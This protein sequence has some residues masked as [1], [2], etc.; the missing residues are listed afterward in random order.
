MEAKKKI[1][2]VKSFGGGGGGL[3]K[4]KKRACPF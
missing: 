2:L 4:Y 3:K 1:Y